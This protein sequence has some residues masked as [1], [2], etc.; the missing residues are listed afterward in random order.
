MGWLGALSRNKVWWRW[1]RNSRCGAPPC[2]NGAIHAS[3]GQRPRNTDSMEPR[4]ESPAQTATA[5]RGWGGLSAL[6]P[7]WDADLGRCPRLVW[8]RAFGPLWLCAFAA[9]RESFIPGLPV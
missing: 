5:A 3:L 6:C 2:A 1:V 7:H 9:S 4:A 8:V